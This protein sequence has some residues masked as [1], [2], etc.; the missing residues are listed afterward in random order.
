MK[1]PTMQTNTTNYFLSI[2]YEL[3]SRGTGYDKANREQHNERTCP[4]P[5]DTAG[6]RTNIMD[7]RGFDSSI[8]LISRGGIPRPIGDFPENLS[9]AISVMLVGR[10]GVDLQGVRVR[11]RRLVAGGHGSAWEPRE[12]SPPTSH[13]ERKVK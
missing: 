12:P 13:D 10:S 7:F 2:Q 3:L 5:S 11:G 8:I 9:Q 1:I 6:F 4:N